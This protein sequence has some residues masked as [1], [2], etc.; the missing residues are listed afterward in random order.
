MI[1]KAVQ[2][3]KPYT[4]GE[5]PRIPNIVKLNTNENAYPPSPKVEAAVRD[6][7]AK[8]LNLYPDPLCVRIREHLATLHGCGIDN[9]FVGNGS[10][11]V[12]RLATG[13]W[14]ENDGAIGFFNPSYSLY[15]VL[16]EIREVPG[17][18]IPLPETRDLP[19]CIA[20]AKLPK[21]PEL[22]FV[23]NPNAPTSTQFPK[24][25]MRAFCERFPGVV[26][27]DEAYAAFAEED[28]LE[29]ALSLPNVVVCRTMS[30]AW[31]LAGIRLGYMIGP[32]DLIESLFKIKD[33]YN[34]NA[35]TQAAALAALDDPDWMRR[36]RDRIVA[37]RARLARELRSRG[38]TVAD[39]ATNFLWCAPPPP[40]TAETV[41]ARLRARGII[42]R[43]FPGPVTGDHIRITIGTDEQ[44]DF[45]LEVLGKGK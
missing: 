32:R 38:W 7:A 15:P 6:F 22:F 11:E 18:A 31:S 20:R 10:D 29:L 12:L 40:A 17:Y 27:I 39:S 30:K 5:Q 3:L 34:V 43:H 1:R 9:I 42:V 13:A 23:A 8:S 14:V 33:S 4:P 37:T 25:A 41:M 44:T 21:A 36:N 26:V 28:C 19:D 2:D 45:L 24:A 35:L 16:A